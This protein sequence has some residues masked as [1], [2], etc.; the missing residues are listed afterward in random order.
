MKLL[1]NIEV[2]TEVNTT[3]NVVNDP[4]NLK[5]NILIPV[6]VYLTTAALLYFIMPKVKQ[7]LKEK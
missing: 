6:V 5:R 2:K 3:V 1:N 4:L 7:S